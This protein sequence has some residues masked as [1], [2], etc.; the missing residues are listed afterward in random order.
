M[1]HIPAVQKKYMLPEE[2]SEE[3]RQVVAQMREQA[4]RLELQAAMKDLQKKPAVK[5]KRPVRNAIK[6]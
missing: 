4:A 3:I 2:S 1:K 6:L 5:K